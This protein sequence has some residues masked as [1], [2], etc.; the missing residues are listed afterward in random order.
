MLAPE[1][2]RGLAIRITDLDGQQ[3]GDLV[4]FSHDL[5]EKLWISN[6]I[7]LNGTTYLTLG[8]VLV[9]RAE[10]AD[11]EGHDGY[12]RTPRPLGRVLQ[13]RDRQCAVSRRG[14]SRV[15]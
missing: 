7:R 15:R 11:A 5:A 9:L 12:M 3:V 4:A 10:S 13:R 1:I 8:H 14:P 2:R 6:T